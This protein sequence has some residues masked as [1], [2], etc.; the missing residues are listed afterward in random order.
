MHSLKGLFVVNSVIGKRVRGNQYFF[1]A[2]SLQCT[3]VLTFVKDICYPQYSFGSV[4]PSLVENDDSSLV[5]CFSSL[6]CFSQ[7]TFVS[8][9]PPR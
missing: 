8:A 9:L 7:H 3:F 2:L 1:K 5:C 6:S 4:S